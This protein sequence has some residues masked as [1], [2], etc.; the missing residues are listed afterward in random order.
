M[1]WYRHRQNL[2]V[3]FFREQKFGNSRND[4]S[5]VCVAHEAVVNDRA[6]TF[7][8][9]NVSANSKRVRCDVDGIARNSVITVLVMTVFRMYEGKFCS[10]LKSLASIKGLYVTG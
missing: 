10:V 7:H 5:R 1:S 8:P 2:P 4:L 3:Y 9:T 6:G